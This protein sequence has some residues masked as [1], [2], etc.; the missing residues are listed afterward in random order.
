MQEKSQTRVVKHGHIGH[1]RNDTFLNSVTEEILSTNKLSKELELEHVGMAQC[2][3]ETIE[4]VV[5][6]QKKKRKNG[7]V[8]SEE[9]KE[10]HEKRKRMGQSRTTACGRTGLFPGTRGFQC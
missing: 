10:L 3:K 6:K 4:A 2:I 9:T 1:R 8:M 5:P 7:R